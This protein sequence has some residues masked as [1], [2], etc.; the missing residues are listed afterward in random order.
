M[1]KILPSRHVAAAEPAAVADQDC[2]GPVVVQAHGDGVGQASD[3]GL[4]RQLRLA[5]KVLTEQAD[6]LRELAKH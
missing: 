6:V 4:Q 3:I 5:R 2:N 1:P